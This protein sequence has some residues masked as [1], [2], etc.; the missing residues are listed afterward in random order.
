MENNEVDSVVKAQP[1]SIKENKE[2][3]FVFEEKIVPL[4]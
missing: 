3:G 4:N 2:R 1:L